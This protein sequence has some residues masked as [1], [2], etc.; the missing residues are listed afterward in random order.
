MPAN[1]NDGTTRPKQCRDDAR[2]AF[3]RA[4]AVRDKWAN[5]KQEKLH[6][7][8]NTASQIGS[9][10]PDGV[11]ASTWA[12]PALPSRGVCTLPLSWLCTLRPVAKV[13]TTPLLAC[14][15][16]GE[17]KPHFHASMLSVATSTKA[18]TKGSTKARRASPTSTSTFPPRHVHLDARLGAQQQTRAPRPSL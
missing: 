18:S 5:T 14:I 11:R 8:E 3:V 1:L 15:A 17:N 16:F 7:D 10:P 12:E 4:A 9:A 6:H 2:A 13:C